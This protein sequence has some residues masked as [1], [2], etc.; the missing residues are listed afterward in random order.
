MAENAIDCLTETASMSQE[1]ICLSCGYRRAWSTLLAAAADGRRHSSEHPRSVE[2]PVL[3]TPID[4][5]APG[6][7]W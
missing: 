5:H 4:R 6:A 2:R 3:V 1:V 7:R